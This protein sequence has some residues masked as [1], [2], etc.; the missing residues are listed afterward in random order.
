VTAKCALLWNTHIWCRELEQE[1]EKILSLDS[2]GSWE[3][4]LVLDAKI[5]GAGDIARK[6]ERCLVIDPDDL[7]GHLPYPAIEGFGI[8]HHSHFP[9]LDFFLSHRDY[10]YYWF[11]EFDVRYSGDWGSFFEIFSPF[12][13]DFIASHIRRYDEEPL[14]HW[15]GTLRH[16]VKTIGQGNCLRSFNVIFRISNRGLV[17]IDREQRDG[18]EGF[19]EVSLP[20]LLHNGGYRILDFGGDG[21][22]TLP[23]LKNRTYTSHGLKDGWLNPFCTMRWRPSRV[24]A[25]LRKNKLY[26]SIKPR[27]MTEPLGER[28]RYLSLWM[29]SFIRYSILRKTR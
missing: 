2:P 13:H 21:D 17:F 7:F 5:P 1:F 15:W 3:V 26:H 28:L 10:D 18:W 8:L 6:Y 16:P 23:Q 27:S 29:Q 4:W 24:R 22:F 20:T 25:G 14:W 9:V 19:N 11:V 12:T